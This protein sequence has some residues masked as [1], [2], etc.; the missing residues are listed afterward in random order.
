MVS[1]RGAS[2]GE[3]LNKHIWVATGKG[4]LAQFIDG[5]WSSHLRRR[6]ARSAYDEQ[7]AISTDYRDS[8]GNIWHSEIG[9]SSGSGLVRYLDLPSRTC[10]L[11]LAQ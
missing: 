6:Q 4:K 5:R 3:D 8:Q 9:W 10:G 1:R 11:P 7:D 2:A